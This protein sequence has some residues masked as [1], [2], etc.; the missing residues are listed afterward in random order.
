MIVREARAED[1]EVACV[2]IRR[3]IVELCRADHQD[4]G[5][6]LAA[7]LANKTPQ[8]V[9]TWIANPDSYMI[10]ADDDGGIFGVAA[11]HNSGK[12]VLN[13]VSPDARFRGVGK[14]L[15]RRL[16]AR[17]SE[18][19]RDTCILDSTGTARQFYR[20]IGYS[21]AGPPT[22]GFGLSPRYPMAKVLAGQR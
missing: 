3:S 22:P 14:S 10:V 17:A 1:A 5:P 8:N 18:L 7:W 9:R 15:M 20:S 13:Y 6:T 11:I 21:E 2:V 4:D 19:G 16:E 12:I